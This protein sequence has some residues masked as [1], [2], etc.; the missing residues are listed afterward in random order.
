MALPRLESRPVP[1]VRRAHPRP[2]RP[3]LLLRHPVRQLRMPLAPVLAIAEYRLGDGLH[4]RLRGYKDAP[5]AEA[6][7]ACAAELAGRVRSWLAADPHPPAPLGS[8]PVGMW[9]PRF[10]PP[11]VRR[12]APAEVLVSQV[13]DL[14]RGHRQAAGARARAHRPPAG[15]PPG[16]RGPSRRSTGRGCAPGGC[17]C[18][19]TASP[20]VPGPRARRPPSGWPGP[21]WWGCW[22]WAG[23]SAGHPSDGRTGGRPR[24]LG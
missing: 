20:P 4:R 7:H 1:G 5:V 6:R 22:P 15:R 18:S 23:P 10:P 24:R 12:V 17:W 13:P 21:G 3:V 11:P 8:G 19:T 9:W 14:A 16:L 2:V